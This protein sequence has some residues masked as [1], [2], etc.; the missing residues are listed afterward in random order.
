MKEEIDI[1]FME[2]QDWALDMAEVSISLHRKRPIKSEGAFGAV[3][4][5]PEMVKVLERLLSAIP[6]QTTMLQEKK[7]QAHLA[8]RVTKLK[9]FQEAGSGRTRRK[10]D[11]TN[12]K[13][14]RCQEK[15]HYARECP[16]PVVVPRGTQ[17]S[18]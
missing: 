17:E 10:S 6:G 16:S 11:K 1:T 12:V 4:V 14:F 15:G 9:A 7:D 3:A 2:L 5:S 13:C 18:N 8:D